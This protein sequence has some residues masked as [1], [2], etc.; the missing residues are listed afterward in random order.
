[1]NFK[2]FFFL[3]TF[4]NEGKISDFLSV[5]YRKVAPEATVCNFRASQLQI[6]L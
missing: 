1:M 2:L 5:L 4:H 6:K 3:L